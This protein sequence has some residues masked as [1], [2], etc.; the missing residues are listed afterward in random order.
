MTHQFD[1]ARALLAVTGDDLRWRR[2]NLGSRRASRSK[3]HVRRAS[4]KARRRLD[5]AVVDLALYYE[6]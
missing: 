2:A 4:S 6:G 5:K 3:R 1:K